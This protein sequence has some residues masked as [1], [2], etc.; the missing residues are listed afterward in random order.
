MRN[1][2][3][4]RMVHSREQWVQPFASCE[5][6]RS[7]LWRVGNTRVA[8]KGHIRMSTDDEGLSHTSE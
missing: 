2:T 1:E 8:S 4:Y 7:E 3:L 6:K 5:L